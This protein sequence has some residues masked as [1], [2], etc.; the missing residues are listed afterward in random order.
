MALVRKSSVTSSSSRPAAWASAT[1]SDS[2]NS[3]WRKR[4]LKTSFTVVPAP[5]G[6]PW[7]HRALRSP[8]S[9][10]SLATRDSGPPTTSRASPLVIVAGAARIGASANRSSPT[11]AA[12]SR[13]VRG[14]TELMSTSAAS[15]ASDSRTPPSPRHTSRTA[16]SAVSRVST[17][18]APVTASAMLSATR[19][20]RPGRSP[21]R[22]GV[23]FQTV[24][25]WP[26]SRSRPATAWPMV[27]S[28]RMLT[29]MAVSS[30][31]VA[32]HH[33]STTAR[34]SSSRRRR[35]A[36]MS[37]LWSRVHIGT[38]WPSGGPSPYTLL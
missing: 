14:W 16:S 17:T 12:S 27:P 33:A 26:R 21:S 3:S 31:Q 11:A 28:P 36:A 10:R 23:R 2:A 25:G 4:R 24:T 13:D 1:A 37:L 18:S 34:A 7:T 9:G 35:S 32:R 22:P 15:G 20:L 38:G 8:N 30:S 29:F 19:A 5:A 6:P